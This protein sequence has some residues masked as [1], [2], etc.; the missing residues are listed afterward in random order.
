MMIGDCPPPHAIEKTMDARIRQR[1]E[2]LELLSAID[3]GKGTASQSRARAQMLN[4]KKSVFISLP[5]IL[6]SRLSLTSASAR[7]TTASRNPHACGLGY[8]A[9]LSAPA[10][11][12]TSRNAASQAGCAGHAGAL[13]RFPSTQ[14]L[15]MAT[16][17]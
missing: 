16:S 14:A 12:S 7:I 11:S 5:T 3:L 2:C 15:S 9:L 6:V 4:G 1:K 17:A 13:T 10:F 8:A